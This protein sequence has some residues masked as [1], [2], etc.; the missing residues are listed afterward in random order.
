MASQGIWMTLHVVFGVS[1]CWLNGGNT[2]NLL[3]II[4]LTKWFNKKLDGILLKLQQTIIS[5][6]SIQ[7]S[8]TQ[9]GLLT[10]KK[11]LLNRQNQ[12][13]GS[14]HDS[15]GILKMICLSRFTTKQSFLKQGPMRETDFDSIYRNIWAGQYR[16]IVFWISSNA[17]R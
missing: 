9:H 5:S 4:Q 12:M 11:Y 10:L 2:T 15:N 14:W 7:F 1:R 17:R 13:C 6:L 8:V 16:D 3:S